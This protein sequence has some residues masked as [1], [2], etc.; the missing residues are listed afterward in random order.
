MHSE[1][2]RA[3]VIPRSLMKDEVFGVKPQVGMVL[4]KPATNGVTTKNNS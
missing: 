1:E 4:F 2:M 3:E